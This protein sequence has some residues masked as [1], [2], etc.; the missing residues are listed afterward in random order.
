[1]E[2]G[3]MK[4]NNYSY[5]LYPF[6][7]AICLAWAV[8]GFLSMKT[9]ADMPLSIDLKSDKKATKTKL[10]DTELILQKNIF[11]AEVS[12]EMISPEV[13]G[14][15]NPAAIAVD[16]GFDGKLVGVLSGDE[17]SMAL[18]E[19]KD[20]MYVLKLLEEQNGL[21]LVEAGYFHVV[22]EKGGEKYK[23]VLKA[24]GKEAPA[25]GKGRTVKLQEDEAG[26]TL[27]SKISRKDVLKELSD[28][29]SVIK[30][31]LIIPFERN[32]NFEG[33]RVRRMTNTSVL[34]KLGVQR[35]DVIMRLNGKSLDSPTV[36]FDTL[37]NAENLS[38]V[39]LDILRSGKKMTLYVEIEG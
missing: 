23:L 30:S 7:I 20:K 14:E 32:G 29:N 16:S 1:M 35:N 25:T 38:A 24:D 11:G 8:T 18:I 9:S 39:S 36:F 21:M 2:Y 34:K 17:Q 31:V 15:E 13:S 10:P 4:L 33:Y 19:Y 26:G 3:E 5:L 22:V 27:K 6:L 37:K 28:V 12:S